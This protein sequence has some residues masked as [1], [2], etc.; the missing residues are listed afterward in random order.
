LL[1]I[2]VINL[3]TNHTEN[4]ATLPAKKLPILLNK[5]FTG[6]GPLLYV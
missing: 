6:E 4:Q 1:S 2:R 3:N 5:D